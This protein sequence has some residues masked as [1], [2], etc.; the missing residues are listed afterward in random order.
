[1]LVFTDVMD[2][3]GRAARNAPGWHA[4]LDTLG[5]LLEGRPLRRSSQERSVELREVYA[6]RFGGEIRTG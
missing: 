5:A 3:R 1:V 2:D 6:E 4:C